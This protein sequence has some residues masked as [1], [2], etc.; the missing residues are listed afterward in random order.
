MGS[1]SAPMIGR[2][3]KRSPRL[4]SRTPKLNYTVNR[5]SD[6][7][8]GYVK[9]DETGWR[10]DSVGHR[11]DSDGRKDFPA[12][13]VHDF[14]DL[15]NPTREP[16]SMPGAAKNPFATEVFAP[17]TG[18]LTAQSIL[19]KQFRPDRRIPAVGSQ[20]RSSDARRIH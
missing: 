9:F 5:T 12:S 16:T 4:S 15:K 18:G 10:I 2:V 13:L 17:S 14:K 1:L 7:S 6:P 19:G 8:Q 20:T 11:D 3:S